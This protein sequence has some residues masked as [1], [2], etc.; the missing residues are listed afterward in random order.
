[1]GSIGERKRTLKIEAKE[2]VLFSPS[3]ALWIQRKT[4]VGPLHSFRKVTCHLRER[5]K[6]L[7]AIRSFSTEK[8][9]LGKSSAGSSKAN[10]RRRNLSVHHLDV[11]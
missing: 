9:I 3:D 5:N 2:I 6:P 7:L 11:N 4:K 1:M 8:V 10:A